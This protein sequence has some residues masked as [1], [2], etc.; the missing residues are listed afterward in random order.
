MQTALEKGLD[1]TSSRLREKAAE[2]SGLF[3]GE[4]DHYSRN[5][6]EHAQ[7]QMQDNARDATERSSQQITEASD[8]AGAKFSERAA[9]LG[10]EQFDLYASKTKMAFEQN[11]AYMEAHTTQIRSKL[12]SDTR[13]FAIEF[14]RA[15][16]Q[17][18]QQTLALGKQEL[19]IEIDQAKG[20]LLIESQALERQF[21]LSLNSQG[22]LAMDEHKHRL[23][24]ASN[25][26]LLTTVTKLNQQSENLINDLADTTEKKLK[27][28]CGSVFSEMGET[29]RQRLAGIAV[30]FGAP[31]T[32]ASPAPTVKSP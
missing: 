17:N 15:L 19:G 12:E 30:P 10:G 22:T 5:Y 23:E 29:L 7:S 28:V 14:Q 24:N 16:A 4:L 6:V 13:V 11:A 3:A 21:Q 31:A 2:T 8:A 18:A 1:Q 25:S 9:Q 27:A 32:P 20:A 26:W